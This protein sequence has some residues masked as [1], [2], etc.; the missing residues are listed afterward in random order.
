MDIEENKY[1]EIVFFYQ[2]RANRKVFKSY[3][4]D[5]PLSSCFEALKWGGQHKD[6]SCRS[7]GKYF[8]LTL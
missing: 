3:S 6:V 5:F 8:S 1:Q 4:G 7:P 2:M